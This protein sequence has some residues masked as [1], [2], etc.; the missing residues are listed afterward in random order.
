MN[1]RDVLNS[2]LAATAMWALGWAGAGRAE[3]KYPERP[4][5]LV[6]PYAPGGAT[7]IVARMFSQR[8]GALIGAPLVID[9]KGGGGGSIGTAEVARAK[10]DGYT[11]LL[12]ASTTQIIN[13]AA[14]EKPTYDGI[15]DFIPITLTGLQ[16]VSI[17]A[18]PA[19]P[20]RTFRELLAEL[21]SHPGEYAYATAGMGSVQHLAGELLK[22]LAGVDIIHVPYKGAAPGMQDVMAGRVALASATMGSVLELHRAGRMRILATFT[23]SRLKSTPEV[24]TAIEGGLPGMLMTTFTGV[25]APAGTPRTIVDQLAAAAAKV[26]NDESY[27]IEM[28]RLGIEPAS[29]ASPEQIQEFIVAASARIAP[30]IKAIGFKME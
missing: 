23:D 30:I 13:P 11:L 21:R 26:L 22:K 5:R 27:R 8:L 24:P 4:I 1:R 10:A 19:M 9:N 20:A 29:P 15:K 28:E 16:S 6:V 18:G 12:G 2:G 3:G 25:F 7:D 14:M 17:A